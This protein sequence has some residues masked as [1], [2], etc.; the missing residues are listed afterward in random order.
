[1]EHAKIIAVDFDGC[2]VTNKWPEIGEPIEEVIRK[3]HLERSHGTRFILWTCRSGEKLEAAV[4]W[5]AE[6]GITFDTV[7]EPLPELVDAFE[8]NP[9]KVFANEY[10]DD[11]A[12][13]MP[14]TCMDS[15]LR[16]RIFREVRQEFKF[17]DIRCRL[18]EMDAEQLH[19]HSAEDLFN[20]EQFLSDVLHRWD[21]SESWV[22]NDVT[23]E[24]CDYAIEEVLKEADEEKEEANG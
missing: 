13:C 1:M 3:Y 4:A 22:D 6:R 5:C 8:G 24:L 15:D 23:W 14:H 10:W 12:V 21:K 17:N 2:L 11:R 7:N 18:E 19:G 9:R 20:D 16:Y